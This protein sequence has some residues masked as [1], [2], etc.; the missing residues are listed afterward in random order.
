[1]FQT[2]WQGAAPAGDG[3][4]DAVPLGPERA[5][6]ALVLANLTRPARSVPR[7]IEGRGV[8]RRLLPKLGGRQLQRG[9]TPF[10]HV[11]R[12][13]ANALGLCERVGFRV[14]REPVI[15]VIALR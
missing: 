10:L 1:M 5:E 13:N 14:H 6:Q 9:E 7:T 12:D 3:C 15:H 4:P 2:V 8:A 11:M